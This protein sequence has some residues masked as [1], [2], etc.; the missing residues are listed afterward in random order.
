[1]TLFDDPGDYEAFERVVEEAVERTGIRLLC[2]CVMPNH[3]HFMIWPR[4][5]GELSDVMRWLT[6]THTQRWHAHRR[7]AGT[8]P[9]YQGRF[10]SFPVQSDEHLLTVARYVER[11]AV[12]ANLVARAEDWRWSSLWRRGHGGALPAE[13]LSRW[14]VA[15]PP[16]WVRRVNCA[17]TVGELDALRRSVQRGQPYGSDHWVQYAA[18]R[19]DLESSL[20][21]PG[22]PRKE[23]LR[24]SK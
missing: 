16:D 22:R 2:Y 9:V 14:P 8:G 6:V 7:T 23:P 19:L 15:M 17:L 12:R 10:K 21:P 24:Q 4:K 18:K 1:M 5:D 13:V 3:W 20:R 11:N